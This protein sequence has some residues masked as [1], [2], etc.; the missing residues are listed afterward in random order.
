MFAAGE[1]NKG[2]IK[3]W[4]ESVFTIGVMDEVRR[5]REVESFCVGTATT[6]DLRW[7]DLDIWGVRG[8]GTKRLVEKE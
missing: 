3:P 1:K 4:E 8:E 2:E 5:K 7:G 6:A